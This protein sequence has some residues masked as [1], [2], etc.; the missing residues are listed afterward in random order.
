MSDQS[1]TEMNY[2]LIEEKDFKR[3]RRMLTHIEKNDSRVIERLVNSLMKYNYQFEKPAAMLNFLVC[4]IAENIAAFPEITEK[5]MWTFSSTNII[6]SIHR[7]IMEKLVF[8]DDSCDFLNSL[9]QFVFCNL[10]PHMSN[11]IDFAVFHKRFK[12]AEIIM[13]RT[14]IYPV[15]NSFLSFLP[16]KFDLFFSWI[17][18]N[19]FEAADAAVRI[20]GLENLFHNYKIIFYSDADFSVRTIKKICRRYMNVS[21]FKNENEALCELMKRTDFPEVYLYSVFTEYREPEIKNIIS[22]LSFLEKI[23]Y[24]SD[25]LSFAVFAAAILDKKPDKSK[26]DRFLKDHVF[27]LA[28][29]EPYINA[30]VAVLLDEYRGRLFSEVFPNAVI[31]VHEAPYIDK[32]LLFRMDKDSPQNGIKNFP[33][34]FESPEKLS[35]DPFIECLESYIESCW[36]NEKKAQ[37]CE[38]YLNTLISNSG[39]T[40]EKYNSLRCG[41]DQ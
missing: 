33:V 30:E 4:Q 2:N 10:Q 41:E 9:P 18:N 26:T 19:I 5:E 25:N 21:D 12:E 37:F 40:K 8:Y 1:P 31:R 36:Y 13:K 3:C 34:I 11:L 32:D 7:L 17:K 22:F 29:S 28:G 16:V 35:S 27:S 15:N 23:G 24:R 14:E 39:I 6:Q 20:F 38:D